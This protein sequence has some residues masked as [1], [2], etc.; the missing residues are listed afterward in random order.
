MMKKWWSFFARLFNAIKIAPSDDS[1]VEANP[2]LGSG[3]GVPC[4]ENQFGLSGTWGEI[5]N[6]HDSGFGND[7]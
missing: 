4:A 5:K 6:H 1:E 2:A 7:F 3:F